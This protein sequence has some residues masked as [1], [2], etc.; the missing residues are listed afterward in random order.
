[1]RYLRFLWQR[2]RYGFSNRELWNLDYTVAKFILPRLKRFREISGGYP[3]QLSEQEWNAVLD[4]MIIAFQLITN[5][6]R[7][8]EHEEIVRI[9]EGLELFGKWFPHLWY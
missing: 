8:V 6:D 3:A 4:K 2:F 7:W 5:G 9:D 1:M